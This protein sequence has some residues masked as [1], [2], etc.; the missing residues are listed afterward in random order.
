MSAAL[1]GSLLLAERGLV[2]PSETG[3][4]TLVAL[5]W[6]QVIENVEA[7]PAHGPD[8]V[9]LQSLLKSQRFVCLPLAEGHD[10]STRK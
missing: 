5:F 10:K 9:D 1:K 6:K 4:W 8:D 7:T 2:V 3:S